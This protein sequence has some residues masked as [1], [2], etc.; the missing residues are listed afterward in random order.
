MAPVELITKKLY[1][2]LSLKSPP[3]NA[4]SLAV[5]T[6]M[7]NALD[8][9]E[10]NP[11][12]KGLIITSAVTNQQ[13]PIFTAGNDL[14]QLYAPMTSG[15]KFREFWL[16]QTTFLTRLYSSRLV[17]VAC[18]NGTSPA[19]G[20]GISL[21]CDYRIMTDSQSSNGFAK[22]GLNEVS[23]GIMVPKYWGKLFLQTAGS[24]G[25]AEKLL[26]TGQMLTPEQAL[27]LGI[28]DEVV[29]LQQVL[30]RGEQLMQ[31]QFTKIP[32]AGYAL[33]KRVL[34]EDFA[35]QWQNYGEE[36]ARQAWKQ[37]QQES[38]V[39]SLGNILQSLSGKKKSK[40]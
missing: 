16:A 27:K 38:I 2:V 37:L 29:P 3:V 5:W 10:K 21:C 39:S 36:E 12:I 14:T 20:C 15:E 6:Q 30:E 7:L 18:I 11:D 22:I 32:S 31:T 13:K 25:H 19:G 35:Q 40:L 9:C 4:L 8:S 24:R 34:R 1:A 17:T 26:L 33:T 28:V 23:I